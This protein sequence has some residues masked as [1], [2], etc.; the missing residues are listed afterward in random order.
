MIDLHPLA[1]YYA[2]LGLV[3]IPLNGKN[4]SAA[5]GKKPLYQRMPPST[6]GL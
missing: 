4:R 2:A 1:K 5:D 3:V 6:F